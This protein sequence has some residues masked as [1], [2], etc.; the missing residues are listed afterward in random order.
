MRFTGSFNTHK[1]IYENETCAI[2]I[3]QASE[4]LRSADNMLSGN[5]ET[6]P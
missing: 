4:T 5:S 6:K 1:Y 3:I 2:V